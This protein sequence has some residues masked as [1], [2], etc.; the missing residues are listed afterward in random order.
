MNIFDLKEYFSQNSAI[1]LESLVGDLLAKNISLTKNLGSFRFILGRYCEESPDQNHSASEMFLQTFCNKNRLYFKK[2]LW[3]AYS[4]KL[5]IYK[6]YNL[7]LHLCRISWS[8]R[9]TLWKI[10]VV[11]FFLKLCEKHPYKNRGFLRI[12]LFL[13][14]LEKI[15]GVFK[16][17]FQ[18]ITWL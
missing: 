2:V 13:P 17:I 16:N 1:F 9:R 8:Y 4:Q 12:F 11:E 6:K 15:F 10:K 14:S 18:R 3:S 5:T 7:R